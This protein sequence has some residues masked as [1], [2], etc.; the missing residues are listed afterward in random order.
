MEEETTVKKRRQGWHGNSEAHA[1]AGRKGGRSC[2]EKYGASHMA[3]LGRKGGTK[4]S[5]DRQ[6][7]AEIGRIGGQTKAGENV[8]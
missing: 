1:A 6:H 2:V 7:M 5:S 3:E 8:R 4:T